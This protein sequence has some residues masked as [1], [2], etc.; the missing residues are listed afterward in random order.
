MGIVLS[1][2]M[3]LVIIV[4]IMVAMVVMLLL[5]MVVIIVVIFGA[6]TLVIFKGADLMQQ[7]ELASEHFFTFLLM[8]G[9]VAGS[10]GGMAAQFSA[11]QRGLGAIESVM[12]IVDQE[13]EVEDLNASTPDLSL[14]K[15][16][17]LT[18]VHFNYP[19]RPDVHVLKGLNLRIDAGDQVAWSARVARA[20]APWPP[21]SSLPRAGHRRP[22]G[23]RR[24]RQR[25]RPARVPTARGVCSPGGDLVWR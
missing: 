19:Q 10:I 5:V 6:I 22:A 16:V 25:P 11:L 9:L 1:M 13:R 14:R 8:T 17:T 3:V 21:P 2:S 7:G 23:R 12:D 18:D 4:V 20:K 15:T 24:A